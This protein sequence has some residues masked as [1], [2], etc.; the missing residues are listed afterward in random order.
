MLQKRGGKREEISCLGGLQSSEFVSPAFRF[1][2]DSAHSLGPAQL[3]G[4]LGLLL[5]SGQSGGQ[6][7]GLF[8][9]A[10][11]DDEDIH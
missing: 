10:R 11:A 9:G 8:D 3:T 6:I 1:E 7:P 5:S 4:G 2:Y